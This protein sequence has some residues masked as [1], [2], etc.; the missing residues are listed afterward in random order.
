MTVGSFH[1]QGL[2]QEMG[3]TACVTATIYRRLLPE[4]SDASTTYW[5]RTGART[6]GEQFS[7]LDETGAISDAVVELHGL[8]I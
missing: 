8:M 1:A 5:K 6:S 7:I 3:I 4:K 2:A